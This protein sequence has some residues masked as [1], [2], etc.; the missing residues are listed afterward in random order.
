MPFLDPKQCRHPYTE[1]QNA[2]RPNMFVITMDMVPPEFYRSSGQCRDHMEMPAWQRLVSDSV[3]FSNAFSVSPLCG[4]SRA[5]LFTGRYPYVQVNE[6]RAHDGFEV[7]VRPD[8]PIFP[9]YLKASGYMTAHIGKSHIGT[10][11]FIQAFGE[12]CSPWNR[13]A[14]PV[15]DDPEYHDFLKRKGVSDFRYKRCIQ[16]LKVD[17][18]T[19]GNHYGGWLE[20]EDGS[21]FPVEATYPFYLVDRAIAYLDSLIKQRHDATAPLYLQLDFFAPHQPFMIPAGFEEREEKL[22]AEMTLPQGYRRCHERNFRAREGEP[23]IYQTYR[24]NWGVYN[25]DTAFGY[26]IANMLQMEVMDRALGRF[27]DALEQRGLYDE[28]LCLLTADH[29]EMN[30]EEGLLDK[31]VYGHPKVARVPIYLKQPGNAGAGSSVDQP[32]CLLDVAPALLDAA[33][34]QPYAHLDGESLLDRLRSDDTG[35]EKTFVFESGWHVAPNF[36]VAIQIYDGPHSH[37]RYVYNVSSPYDEL[38]DMND[39][40]HTNLISDTAYAQIVNRAL[41]TLHRIF[42]EDPRWRCYRQAFD[43]DKAEQLPMTGGDDQMFIPDHG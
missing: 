41:T 4:P 30:L 22:R 6:E 38:Y 16:G 15:Y 35:R 11:K 13:W 18:K 31:G 33:G 43:I 27:L 21:P 9:E 8:D 2:S 7:E 12:S 39:V 24:R 25:E 20:Q 36:A 26:Y 19:P 23:K 14:P 3:C 1:K 17:G 10:E 5:A 34:V 42:H 40:T 32:V 37:Y 29:G 28:S